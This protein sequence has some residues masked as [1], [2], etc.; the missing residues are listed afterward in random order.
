MH[1]FEVAFVREVGLVLLELLGRHGFLL[2]GAA[3]HLGLHLL[4]LQL[5]V[6]EE[7]GAVVAH[8]G[9]LLIH[10]L[11]RE[12]QVLARLLLLGGSGLLLVAVAVAAGEGGLLSLLQLGYQMLAELL[13][14]I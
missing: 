3:R 10:E 4:L 12:L 7:S 1:V 5:A 9:H 11:R 8:I 6:W 13:K 14:I 2:D